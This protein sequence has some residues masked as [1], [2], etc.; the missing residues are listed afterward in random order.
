MI[1]EIVEWN[2]ARNDLK[3][4]PNLE[5]RMLSE[6]AN[7]FFTAKTPAD[8]LR[9]YA[10]FCFVEFGTIA[11]LAAKK[12]ANIAQWQHEWVHSRDLF[13]WC[14]AQHASM[15]EILRED[16][17]LHLA[18]E[19]IAIIT[20]ANQAKSAQKSADGKVVKGSSY[21]DPIEQIRNLIITDIATREKINAH[22]KGDQTYWN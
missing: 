8:R 9:E 20:A 18:T 13:K 21:S 6:E 2:L 16:Q 22:D 11:K 7:E 19:A 12:Y 10:D 14:E 5:I 4:D 1:R 17:T 3:F 15:Q